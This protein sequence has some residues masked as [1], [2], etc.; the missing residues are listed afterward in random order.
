[1]TETHYMTLIDS[2]WLALILTECMYMCVC[3]HVCTVPAYSGV[4]I[5][6][7]SQVYADVGA[8]ACVGGQSLPMWAEPL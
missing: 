5:S 3:V 8:P 6:L 1:M 7:V 2:W 4:I